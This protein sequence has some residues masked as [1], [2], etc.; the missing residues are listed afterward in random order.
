[1]NYSSIMCLAGPEKLA[2]SAAPTDALMAQI[3]TGIDA[4]QYRA[5]RRPSWVS[6]RLLW[7]IPRG[8]WSLRGFFAN[9]LFALLAPQ[10]AH[11]IH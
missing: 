8:L 1:M 9:A 6:A 3:L 10:R 11:Q 5:A 2:R 7:L 4:E